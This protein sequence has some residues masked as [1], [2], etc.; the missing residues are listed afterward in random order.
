MLG[1]HPLLVRELR[2]NGHRA[3]ATVLELQRTHYTETIGDAAVVS[4]TP[5]LGD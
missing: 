2:E 1:H 4:N 3:T 5:L